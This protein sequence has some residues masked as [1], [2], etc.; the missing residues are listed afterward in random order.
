MAAGQLIAGIFNGLCISLLLA[1]ASVPAC[2]PGTASPAPGPVLEFTHSGAWSW[3]QGPRAIHVSGRRNRTYAGWVTRDGRLQV[4]A[5]DHATGELERVTIKEQ[6][7]IDDHNNNSFLVLPDNRIMIF[8]AEHNRTGLY[9]R[10]TSHPEDISQ[11]GEEIVVS[12][13]HGI[14]YSQPVYLRD[15]KKL[16]VFWRG[17][18]WK[19]TFS[20]ST[21]GVVWSASRV[22]LQ[23]RGRENRS[24]R[25][26]LKLVSDGRSEIHFAFTDAHPAN[27]E[28]NS[29]YYLKY[30]GGSFY[31]ADGAVVG[32]MDRLP[33]QHRDSDLVYDAR[34]SKVRGWV[35]DIALSDKG[36]PV[37]AY[38]RLPHPA[39]HRYHYAHWDGLAWR[40]EEI[41][42]GGPWFPQTPS[43][44][45]EREPYYSGGIVIDHQNPSVVYL[46]RPVNGVFEIE[47]WTVSGTGRRWSSSAIT[48]GS[49]QHNVR[50]VVP[51][52]NDRSA[53]AIFWMSGGYVHYTE[54]DTR[55]LM[56]SLL[57]VATAPDAADVRGPLP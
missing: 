54:F 7:E 51:R 16:Y 45:T 26:Y 57:P 15:E 12:A 8:Y 40:D 21:D 41:T 48:K 30:R 36:A 43:N 37:I 28:Q 49:K 5:Y 2:S 38:T 29:I 31:K 18:S 35:W 3:F 13:A 55:I 56:R 34:T 4:G 11:W 52:G 46:S 19:P 25:P 50:P 6:W 24:V 10:I 44:V 22:L 47:R 39:D 1:A 17:E 23:D 14:T 27:E 9:A 32:S 33:I 53:A 20:T 42:P